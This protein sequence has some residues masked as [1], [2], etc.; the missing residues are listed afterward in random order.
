MKRKQ[1]GCNKTRKIAIYQLGATKERRNNTTGS[2]NL[3]SNKI[4]RKKKRFFRAIIVKLFLFKRH[5][6]VKHLVQVIY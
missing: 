2:Q 5:S 4:I 3:S 1:T 6:L